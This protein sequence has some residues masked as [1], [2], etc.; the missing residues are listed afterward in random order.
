MIASSFNGCQK[1]GSCLEVIKQCILPD[2][3]RSQGEAGLHP[4]VGHPLL[5]DRINKLSIP[6]AGK[7]QTNFDESRTGVNSTDWSKIS[8]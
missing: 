4:E 8:I 6:F 7:A 1:L 3:L 2:Y 5:G